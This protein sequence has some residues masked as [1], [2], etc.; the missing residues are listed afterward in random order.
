[1][2]IKNMSKTKKTLKADSEEY[3][4]SRLKN[5]LYLVNTKIS[6]HEKKL[7]NLSEDSDILKLTRDL[8][9]LKTKRTSYL[10]SLEKKGY[11]IK[12]GRPKKNDSEKYKN[13]KEKFTAMLEPIALNYI[14]ALKSDGIIH[15]I[16][17]FLD[18]LILEHMK[19][20]KKIID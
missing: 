15:D 20:I 19:T 17:S 12:K 9:Y 8:N 7:F 18:S 3:Q 14:K 4:L 10:A 13:K 5:C 1:M 11:S 6:E 16:S 2:P